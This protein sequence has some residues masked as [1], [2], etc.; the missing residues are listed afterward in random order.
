[1]SLDTGIITLSYFTYAIPYVR[2]TVLKSF[3]CLWSQRTDILT[4]L[5]PGVEA[6]PVIAFP[7][8]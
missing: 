6:E 5:C 7:S 3:F 2:Q 1:M 8:Y 4:D